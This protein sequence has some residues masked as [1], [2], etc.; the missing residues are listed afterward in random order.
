M[1]ESMT[2]MLIL[3]IMEDSN[4]RSIMDQNS[5]SKA[6][7][8]AEEVTRITKVVRNVVTPAYGKDSFQCKKK[9]HFSAYC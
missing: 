3:S 9:G 1:L 8:I 7:A 2:K 4:P 5:G 6:I